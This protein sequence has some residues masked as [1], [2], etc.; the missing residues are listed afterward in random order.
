MAKEK[1]LLSP[2]QIHKLETNQH[3]RGHI[4]GGTQLEQD[5]L[6]RKYHAFIV[7]IPLMPKFFIMYCLEKNLIRFFPSFINPFLLVNITKIIKRDKYNEFRV[8]GWWMIVIET[9]N[10]LINLVKK[11]FRKREFKINK[12]QIRYDN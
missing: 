11:I 5:K 7:L 9:K 1:K 10:L 8:R 2:E 4:A 6:S 12:V 3:S